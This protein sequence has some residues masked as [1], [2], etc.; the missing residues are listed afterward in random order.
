MKFNGHYIN[1]RNKRI[2]FILSHLNVKDKSILML[3]DGEGDIANKFQKK[4]AKVSVIEG[5]PEHCTNGSI[6]FPKV[7]FYCADLNGYRISDKYD[8][9]ISM[10]LLYHLSDPIHHL[11]QICS[12]AETIV[13]ETEVLD[14][15]IGYELIKEPMKL[16]DQSLDGIGCHVTADLIEATF[17]KYDVDYIRYDD[18]KLNS[19]FHRYDWPSNFN[20]H[21]E[22]GQRRFWIAK[23]TIWNTFIKNATDGSHSQSSTQKSLAA[24]KAEPSSRSEP[25]QDNPSPIY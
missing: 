13:I 5:R 23:N 24:L 16:Y 2:K 12:C 6:R 21:Y 14:A 15:L 4:G 17:N 20:R 10:G 1:W 18:S 8:I 9:V 3:G 11:R 25:M 7:H 22:N 19:D